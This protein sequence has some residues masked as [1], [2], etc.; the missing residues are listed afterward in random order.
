MSD[1]IKLTATLVII[2]ITAGLAIA[3]TNGKTVDKIAE[4]KLQAEQLALK[5]VFEEGSEISVIEHDTIIGEKYWTSSKGGTLTGYAF[6]GSSRGFSSD[7]EFIAGVNPEGK[8]LGLVILS[9]AETPGLGTRV[10]EIVSRKYIWNAFS[11]KDKET[12]SA[13]WF[14][15][16]FRGITV[17]EDISI[18]KS[19]E[20]HLKTDEDRKSLP[21]KMLFQ[22]LLVLLY[23]QKL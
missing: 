22:P 12:K 16:Q 2:S 5:S 18:D 1:I 11:N 21:V 14:T 7:I 3:F 6:K 8:I 10:E 13:P 20:W 15:E 17:R 4:Q 19:G 23:L 9:Q